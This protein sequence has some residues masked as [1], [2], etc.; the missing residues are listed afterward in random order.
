MTS[1][2]DPAQELHA[3]LRA[4]GLADRGD[5]GRIRATGRDVLDLLHRLSTA[6]LR[7]LLPGQGRPTVLTTGKGRIV[8]R[9]FVHRLDEGVVMLF[10][11]PAEAPAVRAHIDRFTFAEDT[12]LSDISAQ[13]C[14][15]SVIG[16]TGRSALA[17]A[18]IP[19]PPPCESLR[20]TI[21]G[22]DAWVLGQDGFTAEGISI[23]A[24]LEDADRLRAVLTRAVAAAQGQPIG[25]Q[26]L[27]AWRVLRGH[28]ASGHELTEDRN[29]LEAGL[30]DAISF[31][32]GCYVGQEVVA[33]LRTYDRV[34][35]SLVGLVFPPGE[36]MPASERKLFYE[37]R[38][39]GEVTSA[40]VPPG[41]NSE[42]A[43]AYVK[44]NAASPGAT[45]R[46]GGPDAALAARV[47]PLPFEP[48]P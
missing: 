44:R 43:L 19:L 4:C 41:G 36:L 31:T 5:L 17:A 21:E 22:C 6:D 2:T 23:V 14:Q 40:V 27:E 9:L 34:S 25:A 46:V 37:G 29:P 18:A 38:E 20:V 24:S 45:L 30:T 35:R 33:R 42:V 16:P 11:G 15:L 28:P 1:S 8:A 39:V 10:T 13:T 47:T 26:A 12:G 48:I 7:G 32:K 3:A